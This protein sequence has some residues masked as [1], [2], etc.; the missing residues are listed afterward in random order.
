MFAGV[1]STAPDGPSKWLSSPRF[2]YITEQRH[3]G[4]AHRG[5]TASLREASVKAEG[6]SGDE[7]WK[8][9]I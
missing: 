9:L 8:Y 6:R 3:R 2:E 5:N 4:M 1:C 7:I